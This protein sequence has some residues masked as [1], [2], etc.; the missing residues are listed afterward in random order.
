MHKQP[1]FQLQMELDQVAQSLPASLGKILENHHFQN[2]ICGLKNSRAIL[3]DFLFPSIMSG[4][5]L[6]MDFALL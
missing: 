6:S 1:T 3:T 4:G 5:G 2:D